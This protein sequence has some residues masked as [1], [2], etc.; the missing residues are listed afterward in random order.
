MN[1]TE[2]PKK[3]KS[4]FVWFTFF[5]SYLVDFCFSSS[6]KFSSCSFTF[7]EI[8]KSHK[9]FN[10]CEFCECIRWGEH[11]M[12][13]I[14]NQV[15]TSKSA[16]SP[17]RRNSNVGSCICFVIITNCTRYYLLGGPSHFF[18]VHCWCEAGCENARNFSC[19]T[20]GIEHSNRK[21]P[22]D[23]YQR[24]NLSHFISMQTA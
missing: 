10:A 4:E 3:P 23:L 5:V 18:S 1:E 2:E 17:H 8:H 20:D 15:Y 16:I 24:S 19:Q 21:A 13:K 14:K 12:N 9:Q 6:F 11:E 22:Q 7:N